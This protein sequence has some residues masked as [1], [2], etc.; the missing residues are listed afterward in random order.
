ME[1][2]GTVIIDTPSLSNY[3][4]GS[5]VPLHPCTAGHVQLRRYDSI[6]NTRRPF[7]LFNV[8]FK[9]GGE[10]TFNG[11]LLHAMEVADPSID[12]FL[13]GDLNFIESPTDSTTANPHLPPMSFIEKWSS[14]K[15]KYH[16]FDPPH[17]THT[18]YHI[19]A[20]PVSPY[21]RASRLDRILYPAALSDHPLLTPSVSIPHHHTNLSP[22]KGGNKSFSD[23]LPVHL[24]YEVKGAKDTPRSSIPVWLASS[25]EFASALRDLWNPVPSRG[26]AYQELTAYKRALFSS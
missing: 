13:C 14:F 1:R 21:S 10:Y 15:N 20:D 5:N 12:T 16:L 2:G 26:G 11:E 18:Y 4:K 7:Q 3:Y 8:Y 17:N 23:H 24:T 25:P 6:D 22:T 19:T 9:S